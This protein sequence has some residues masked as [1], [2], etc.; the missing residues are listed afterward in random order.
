MIV[1][2]RRFGVAVLAAAAVLGLA[3]P[4][5]AAALPDLVPQIYDVQVRVGDVLQGD[6]DEGCA[7]GRFNR[8]LVK[9]SL[10]TN[11]VGA[12][13]LVMGSPGCPNCT[14]NPGAVCTNPLYVCSTA[15]GHAHFESYAKNEILDADDNVV[16]EGRKY[17]FCLLDLNC[18]TPHYSCSYQGITAGCHDVYSAGLPCQYVDI[19][20][21]AL[22]DGVY[23][24]RVTIDPDN[25]LEESDDSNNVM[26]VPFTLGETERV[27]PIYPSTDVPTAIPDEGSVASTVTI[28]D[29]GPVTSLRLHMNGTHTF[30]GDLD[31]TLTSPALTTRSLFS[32]ICGS[33]DN[34]SVYLGDGAIDALVC[35]PTEPTVLRTPAE[36]FAPFLGEG[37]GGDWTLTISDQA[38]G[39]TG[40]LDGW[41]L[42]VCS[43]C[44]DGILN[45]GET[46][47]DGNLDDGDCCSSDCDTAAIDGTVCEDGNMCTVNET[48][49]AGHCVEG[50]PL[51]C[52]PCLVCDA[53][54]GCVVPEVVY[55]C[56]QPPTAGSMI[57][58]HHN[59][60]DP[61][62]DSL[63]WR[64]RS[65][66]PVELDEFGAP[67]VSTDISLCIYDGSLLV[68][69]STIPA[70]QACNDG[71][72][73]WVRNE[74]VAM[75]SD[76]TSGF[77]GMSTMRI[78][79]GDEG[80]IVVRGSGTALALPDLDLSLPTTV[81]MRRGDGTPCWEANFDSAR[82]S[83]EHR[84]KSRSR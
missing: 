79:E 48:C 78:R 28:P 37:A 64:W 65:E 4:Q 83:T 77:G 21:S 6:V 32:N 26:V 59:A 66:T 81:R 56:Q 13:D 42:E 40:T 25:V 10:Q 33:F 44:G 60:D 67:D 57:Q 73:C 84:F 9:F 12:T 38:A 58:L 69:S 49:V 24:L 53:E 39:N 34:F 52:D 23:K 36:S 43:V 3:E 14:L 27:C 61:G 70:A 55:P 8:R 50:G 63:L 31:A 46:C 18:P 71:E 11:N 20:D 72:P 41:S 5:T 2:P 45:D 76:V 15:H 51:A 22:P 80:T 54:L 17:G 30:D 29:I 35:P 16:A 1:Q 75:F 7:G 47:D 19:T 74:H 82:T 62:R 68:L